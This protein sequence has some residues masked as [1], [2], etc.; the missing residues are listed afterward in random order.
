[1]GADFGGKGTDTSQGTIL[2]LRR[3]ETQIVK[4]GM[5]EET[6][7]SDYQ[8][9]N[10]KNQIPRTKFQRLHWFL[11]LGI[12]FF[13]L[14]LTTHLLT[15]HIY[16]PLMSAAGAFVAVVVAVLIVA[17][18]GTAVVGSGLGGGGRLGNVVFRLCLSHLR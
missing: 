4:H 9:P 17:G 1:M 16:L 7:T 18:T 12:W 15:T 6:P 5:L 3:P 11:V 14:P 10:S 2:F 13:G 8:E